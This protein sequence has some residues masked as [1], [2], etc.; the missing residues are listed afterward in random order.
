MLSAAVSCSALCWQ[1]PLFRSLRWWSFDEPLSYVDKHF[2]QQ[3]YHIVADLAKSS[4]I[5]LVS[6]EMTVISGMANKHIIVNRGVEV[7]QNT[8]HGPRS[9]YAALKYHNRE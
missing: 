9:P 2:E 1:G 8:H 4:T 5:I 6:H 7:C 3:I